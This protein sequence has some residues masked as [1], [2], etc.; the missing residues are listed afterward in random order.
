[1]DIVTWTWNLSLI[2]LTIVIWTPESNIVMAKRKKE[3][4]I[5]HYK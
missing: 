4:K 5:V 3:G 2:T 1:M